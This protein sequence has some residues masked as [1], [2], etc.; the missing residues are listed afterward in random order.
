[1]CFFGKT[2]LTCLLDTHRG[3]YLITN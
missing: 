2:Y 3:T 1:M